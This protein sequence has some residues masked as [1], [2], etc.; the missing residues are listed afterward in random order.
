M[1]DG[2]D[3]FVR[4]ARA[5]RLRWRRRFFCA[6]HWPVSAPTISPFVELQLCCRAASSGRGRVGWRKP[7]FA[8]LGEK[9]APALVHRVRVFLILG[10]ELLDEGGVGADKERG[11]SRNLVGRPV[12]VD[13]A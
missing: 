3:G 8:Q 4:G 5:G 11:V 6:G 10:V 13:L 12:Q 2:A 1:L 9:G 7:A